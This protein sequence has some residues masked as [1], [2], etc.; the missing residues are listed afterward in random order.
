MWMGVRPK[1]IELGG[2]SADR[3]KSMKGTGTHPTVL[4]K[5]K[6]GRE[7]S[8]GSNVHLGQAQTQA[9]LGLRKKKTT[10]PET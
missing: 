8:G 10:G 9:C 3:I 2:Q 7:S 5:D 1:A 4:W 6:T